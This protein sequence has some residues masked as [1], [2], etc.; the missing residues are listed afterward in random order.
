M[1]RSVKICL[2]AAAALILLGVLSIGAA[3]AA[4]HWDL[5]L[6]SG[7]NYVTNT[8]T[9]ND[10]FRN[11]SIDCDTEDIVFRTAADGTCSVIFFEEETERTAEHGTTASCGFPRN[12]RPSR[13][14][15]RAAN[16]ILFS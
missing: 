13:S 14:A 5:S 9:I 2:L 4:N 1:K 12:P 16:M 10:A 3:M 15:C 8:V 11:I 7:T 6:L